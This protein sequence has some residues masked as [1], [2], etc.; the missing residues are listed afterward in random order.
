MHEQSQ[1]EARQPISPVSGGVPIKQNRQ[2][3]HCSVHWSFNVLYIHK[4]IYD[5]GCSDDSCSLVRCYSDVVLHAVVLAQCTDVQKGA[6]THNA[7]TC[8]FSSAEQYT[9]Y[10]PVCGW[11]IHKC[12]Y[13]KSDDEIGVGMSAWLENLSRF[14]FVDDAETAAA[15]SSASPS[16]SS[17]SAALYGFE[18]LTTSHP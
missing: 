18:T 5:F 10:I 1:D 13:D 2:S 8:N 4:D 15:I 3:K 12:V 16:S 14:S 11:A 9:T 17:S 6:H 7:H